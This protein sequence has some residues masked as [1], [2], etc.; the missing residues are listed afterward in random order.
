MNEYPY[1]VTSL[2]CTLEKHTLFFT[3]VCVERQNV[4][5]CVRGVKDLCSSL[6]CPALSFCCVSFTSGFDVRLCAEKV[7]RLDLLN[8][9]IQRLWVTSLSLPKGTVVLLGQVDPV[10]KVKRKNHMY[11]VPWSQFRVS[12]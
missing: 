9:S 2:L 10:I 5:S 4:A 11:T 12:Y 1:S 7:L 6:A 3:Q 8:P